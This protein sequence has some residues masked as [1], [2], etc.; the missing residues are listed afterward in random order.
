MGKI[1][2]NFWT[3]HY[4]VKQFDITDKKKIYDLLLMK[5]KNWLPSSVNFKRTKYK[6][7]FPQII[8]MEKN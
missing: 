6:S 2:I 3:I 8:E 1:N 4:Y 7:D 5:G